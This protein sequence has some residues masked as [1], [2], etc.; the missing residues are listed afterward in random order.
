MTC[1]AVAVCSS[2]GFPPLA[3]LQKIGSNRRMDQ[4]R[5]F[6]IESPRHDIRS[7]VVGKDAL[8][9]K[10]DIYGINPGEHF[11]G[12]D[13]IQDRVSHVIR[14]LHKYVASDSKWVD[15]ETREPIQAWDALAALSDLEE[16]P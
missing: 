11:E 15:C 10:I 12:G 4:E 3:D 8:G 9:F 7:I 1:A 13:Q 16:W 5:W 2:V 14:T 6:E